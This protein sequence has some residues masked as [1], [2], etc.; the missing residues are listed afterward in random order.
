MAWFT[1]LVSLIRATTHRRVSCLLLLPASK[2]GQGYVFTGVCNSVHRGGCLPQCMLGYHTPQE[3]TPPGRRH[4]PWEQTPPPAQ[5]ML[6]DTVNAREVRILLE[7]NLVFF[8]DE[9]ILILKFHLPL[10]LDDW[11]CI[12]GSWLWWIQDFPDKGK[13]RRQ[14]LR[15]EEKP[16]IWQDF[17][18]KLHENERNWTENRGARP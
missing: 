8:L 13:V 12:L 16:I 18:W 4:P 15:F 7:C 9:T 6:G 11:S 17:C 1:C 10:V 2:L 14:S 5:S 3:Q